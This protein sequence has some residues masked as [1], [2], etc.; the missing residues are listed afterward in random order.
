MAIQEFCRLFNVLS[1]AFL[2]VEETK[3]ECSFSLR[4]LVAF[5]K[6]DIEYFEQMLDGLTDVA[7]LRMCLCKL[8]VSLSCGTFVSIF[9]AK[10]EEVLPVLD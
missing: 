4:L 8:L 7:S 9:N 5:F 10:V 3:F 1:L 6:S 2:V